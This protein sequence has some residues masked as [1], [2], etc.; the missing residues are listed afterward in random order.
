MFIILEEYFK[1]T[2][3]TFHSVLSYLKIIWEVRP[4]V[5]LLFFTTPQL[6]GPFILRRLQMKK[7]RKG[8]YL[9]AVKVKQ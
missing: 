9:F 3:F 7:K 2:I 8:P 6:L 4:L 1:K 5:I